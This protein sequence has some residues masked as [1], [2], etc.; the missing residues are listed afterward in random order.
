V[1]RGVSE[2]GGYL[3]TWFCGHGRREC[4]VDSGRASRLFYAVVVGLTVESGPSIQKRDG[5]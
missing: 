4:G 5:V 3:Y 1:V 2:E